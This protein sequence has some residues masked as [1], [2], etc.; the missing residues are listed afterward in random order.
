MKQMKRSLCL[1]LAL[2]LLLLC[3]CSVPGTSAT[4]MEMELS[5]NYD[6]SDPFINEKLFYVSEDIETLEL[7]VTLEM[8]AESGLLEIADNNS[9]AV[10]WSKSWTGAVQE[11]FD[12]SLEDLKTDQEY[13]LRFTG[14]KV[15]HAKITLL[16]ENSLVQ[17][18][19][20][21][22]RPERG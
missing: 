19:E 4:V 6:S 11:T 16:C 22:Q 13:V 12:L 10:V 14:T 9:G 5:A 3:A 8:D 7:Q 18:R 21:P 20:R 2:S 17:E 1:L 15:Q